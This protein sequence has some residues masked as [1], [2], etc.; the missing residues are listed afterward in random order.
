MIIRIEMARQT[1]LEEK[2]KYEKFKRW[3]QEHPELANAR[4]I[5]IVVGEHLKELGFFYLD[6]ILGPIF[7]MSDPLTGLGIIVND[8]LPN[9]ILRENL[10]NLI[11]KAQKSSTVIQVA[12]N[13]T[14][15]TN[16]VS[17]FREIYGLTKEEQIRF[18]ENG[19]V[20]DKWSAE[21]EQYFKKPDKVGTRTDFGQVKYKIRQFE[22]TYPTR[23]TSNW[24]GE[25]RGKVQLYANAEF[26]DG[27]KEALVD[28]TLMPFAIKVF[29]E[30]NQPYYQGKAVVNLDGTWVLSKTW[31]TRGTANVVYGEI[32]DAEGN[33]ISTTPKVRIYLE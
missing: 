6:T 11:D 31:P 29:I 2:E 3:E 1:A 9:G 28:Y 4:N 23:N 18:L 8:Y 17:L 15:W 13:P 33:K 22:I 19:K 16:Y 14:D 25:V 21:V 24:D 12:L 7:D 5:A 20:Y 32:Y 30:T 10:L 26:P 27:T